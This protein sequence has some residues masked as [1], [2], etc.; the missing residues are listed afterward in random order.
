MRLGDIEDY[1]EIKRNPVES[2]G[3]TLIGI[4]SAI[5][6]VIGCA[7]S[8]YLIVKSESSIEFSVS[9]VLL[10]IILLSCFVYYLKKYK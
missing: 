5:G 7:A 6:C 2:K 10:F 3:V 9:M 4:Y 1:T 8:A